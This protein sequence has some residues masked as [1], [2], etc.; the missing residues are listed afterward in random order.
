MAY[1]E[2]AP[3]VL[4]AARVDLLNDIREALAN[5]NV[6]L[7]Q[8]ETK[9]E[10]IALLERLKSQ[11]DLAIVEI[12][13]PEFGAWDLIRQL[14]RRPRKPVKVIAT[15]STFPEPYFKKIKELGVD[16]VVQAAIP[17]EAWRKTVE[18]LLVKNQNTL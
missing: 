7:L 6:A 5:T 13:L 11:I 2:K 17:P 12:E 10:A 1:G 4:V 3:I 9:Q 14:T 18:A 15:T 16:E 8:A